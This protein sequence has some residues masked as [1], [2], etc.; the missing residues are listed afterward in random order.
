MTSRP[1]RLSLA[2]SALVAIPAIALS[3]AAPTSVWDGAY[4]QAQADRGQAQYKAHCAACHGDA[5]NGGDSAPPLAGGNFLSNWNQQ[6]AGDL[7]TRIKTTMPLDAPG[8]LGSPTVSDIE[9]FLL[10]KNGFPAGQADL[11][12]DPALLG[13]VTIT[14]DK[15]GQ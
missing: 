2:A 6:S 9:A 11:A 10:S 14:Q 8:S 5:L 13:R 3:A 15:P 1:F 12:R 7:F 4:S